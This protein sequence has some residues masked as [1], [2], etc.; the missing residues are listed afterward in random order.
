VDKVRQLK[1]LISETKSKALIQVDGGVNAQTA[2]LLV[3]AGADSL[4]SGNYIFRAKE[5]IGTISELKRLGENI[6]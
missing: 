6:R 1:R 2:P 3:A 4:V 5:P